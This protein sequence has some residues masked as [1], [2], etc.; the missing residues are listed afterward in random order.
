MVDSQEF[1]DILNQPQDKE[2]YMGDWGKTQGYFTGDRVTFGDKL[3]IAK[4]DVPP[5]T[6]PTGDPTTDPYWALDPSETFKETMSTYNKNIE[7]N[8]AILAQAEAEVPLSGY[9][10]N[11]YYVIATTPEGDIDGQ[12]TRVDS[13]QVTGDNIDINTAAQGVSPRPE[14]DGYR[15]GYLTGDGLPPNG[16]PV[17][18]GVTFPDNPSLGD[19]CLR[20][21]YMPNRLFR[22]DGRHWVKFEDSV[23]TPLTPPTGVAGKGTTE[24]YSFY[25]N[26]AEI[27]TTDRG[28]IPSKQSLSK[29]LRPKDDN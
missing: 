29:A 13:T 9:D 26:D 20:L 10:V 7:I 22:Y 28:K 4:Q 3:Y 2:N 25:D 23:R 11:P 18:P 17:T 1:A 27:Q 24:H 15:L 14:D 16:F 12:N 6:P 8:N 5:D 19:F 21:D